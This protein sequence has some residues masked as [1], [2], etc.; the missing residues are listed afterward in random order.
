[1][2]LHRLALAGLVAAVLAVAG[3]ARAA[4]FFE[5]NFWLSGPNYSAN[6]PLC[7]NGFALFTTRFKF[8]QKERRFWESNL[9]ILEIDEIQETAF[10]PG[11]YAA[12]PRRYCKGV[13][14]VSDGIRRPIYY[15]I[16]E[17][18]GFAGGIWGV[19]WCVVGLDRNWAYNPRCKMAMP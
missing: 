8:A 17:D 1:M 11:H 7:E 12:I 5:M 18:T 6:V 10:R 19:E 15:S 3:S 9:R 16:A 4:N 14:V 2:H 13:A